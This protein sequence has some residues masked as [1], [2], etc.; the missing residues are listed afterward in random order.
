MPEPLPA[1]PV[2]LFPTLN[3]DLEEFTLGLFLEK[4]EFA[5]GGSGGG[6]AGDDAARAALTAS[7]IG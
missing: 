3:E 5:T 6:P 7:S 2:V 4:A 1:G